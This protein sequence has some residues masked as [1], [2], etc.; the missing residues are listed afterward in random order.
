MK[1]TIKEF[2]QEAQPSIKELER[3]ECLRLRPLWEEVFAED[4]Q[5]FTDYYFKEKALRNHAFALQKDTTVDTAGNTGYISML[6][7][8]P[9]DMMLRSGNGFVCKTVD[10]IIGVATKKEYRHKG[11]MD[12]L[13]K[14]ALKHMYGNGRPFTFL[15]PANPEI[16]EPYQF[17]YIYDR[18]IYELREAVRLEEAIKEEEMQEAADYAFRWLSAETDVFIKRDLEYYRVMRK[19]LQAQNGGIYPLRKQGG[20]NGIFLYTEEAGRG[21]IQEAV[22]SAWPVISTGKKI[23]AIMARIVNMQELL[24]LLRASEGKA[25]VILKV[26]DPIL[27][28]NGGT[29]KCE[30]AEDKAKV[31]KCS[32]ETDMVSA[33]IENLTEWIFGYIGAE[34]CFGFPEDWN[35]D[36]KEA[37]LCK[38]NK[39]KVLQKVF[40][41]EIV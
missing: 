19:E 21:E 8:A 36:Q 23:P 28:G 6:Y 31:C 29:W 27:E 13:L 38:L 37:L 12:R 2:E 41:N 11:Y 3:E 5:A 7:L 25:D 18:E 20:V 16:Y 24:K 40:I 30:F 34:A 33:P 14:A 35:T 10:Y 1:D 26:T 32:A 17:R 15:M 4:T 9:Y 22:N 39:I